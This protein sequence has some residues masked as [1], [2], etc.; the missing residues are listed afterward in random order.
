MAMEEWLNG[1][2]GNELDGGGDKLDGR[3]GDGLDSGGRIRLPPAALALFSPSCSTWPA[4]AM[5]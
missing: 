2:A 4:M 3:G 1:A 5:E